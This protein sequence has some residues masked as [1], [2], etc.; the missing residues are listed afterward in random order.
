VAPVAPFLPNTV[1]ASINPHFAYQVYLGDN[2]DVAAKEMDVDIRKSIRSCAQTAKSNIPA[3]FLTHT[4]DFLG[5]WNKFL[6]ANNSQQIPSSGIMS[7]VVE[8][9]MVYSYKKQGF[10]NTYNGYQ[11]LNRKISFDFGVAQGNL[12]LSQPTFTLRPTADPVSNWVELAS[13]VGEAKFLTN[14]QTAEIPSSHWPQ[15][16]LPDQ[17]NSILSTWLGGIT[18]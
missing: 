9:Y 5:P 14:H 8:D 6:A 12:T 10:Y 16:E 11:S 3:E 4:T 7:Q 18:F 13:T 17:F 1:L 15:E 2:P